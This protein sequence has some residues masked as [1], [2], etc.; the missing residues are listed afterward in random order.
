MI[1]ILNYE[2]FLKI[3]NKVNEI[4]QENKIYPSKLDSVISDGDHEITIAKR[5]ESAVS[6]MAATKSSNISDLLKTVGNTIIITIGG[7]AVPV[8]GLFFSEMDKNIEKTKNSVDMFDLYNIFKTA[9]K[10]V[11]KLGKSAKP[12][13]KTMVDALYPAVKSFEQSA[14]AGID[15]KPLLRE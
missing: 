15:I 4:I 9:L 8:F 14:N 1:T 5:F 12:G 7:V 10:K 13:D 3:V 6:K 11:I 2:D